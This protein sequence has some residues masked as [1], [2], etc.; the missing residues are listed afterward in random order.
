LIATAASG[1][2]TLYLQNVPGMHESIR[3]GLA[4]PKIF[5]Q[6]VRNLLEKMKIKVVETRF[7]RIAFLDG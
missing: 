6:V 2:E 5:V 1:Q 3:E 7:S 4:T